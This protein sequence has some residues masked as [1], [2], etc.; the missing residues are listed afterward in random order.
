MSPRD[1]DF[2]P[3]EPKFRR[4][5]ALEQVPEGPSRRPRGL[6][7][8]SISTGVV[9]VA[10]VVAL[11]M[12]WGTTTEPVAVDQDGQSEGVTG[13][14]ETG[15]EDGDLIGPDAT[16]P[17]H[18]VSAGDTVPID[19]DA[20]FPDGVTLLPPELGDW[21]EQD[22]INRPDQ[23]TAVSPDYGAS[24]EVWQ[25][26]VFDTPQSDEALTIAQLNRVGDECSASS[27]VRPQGDPVVDVL[28]GADDTKLEVLVAK[29]DGCDGGEL[30]LVERVMPLTGAR[31]HIVLWDSTSVAGNEEL[32]AMYHAI[33][34][35]F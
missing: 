21:T 24:I 13:P 2:R 15:A 18:T 31:F 3:P 4:Q 29:V 20:L 5:D 19:V 27:N 25:T 26:S 35:E 32:M 30:W 16:H 1:Y 6:I 9:V 22:I 28:T 11:V 14:T 10:L 8:A 33:S 34:F 7:F 12:L 23:F 17:P